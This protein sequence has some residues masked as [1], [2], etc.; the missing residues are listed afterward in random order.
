M[1]DIRL[2]VMQFVGVSVPAVTVGQNIEQRRRPAVLNKPNQ[3]F[4]I[5]GERR[6]IVE[7]QFRGRWVAIHRFVVA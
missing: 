4:C 2:F 7:T 3:Q 5:K 6:K 1:I